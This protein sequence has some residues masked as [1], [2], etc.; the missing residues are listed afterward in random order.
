MLLQ[1]PRPKGKSLQA[2]PLLPSTDKGHRTCVLSASSQLTTGAVFLKSSCGCMNWADK[3]GW[4][5]GRLL[6]VTVPSCSDAGQFCFG[7]AQQQLCPSGPCIGKQGDS[8][9]RLQEA[10]T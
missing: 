1:C 7:A 6:S 3:V 8:N 2:V 5:V 10:L 9:S 4:P